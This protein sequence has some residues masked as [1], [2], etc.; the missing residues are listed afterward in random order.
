MAAQ[1]GTVHTVI[2]DASSI[3]RLDSSA[4]GALGEIARSLEASGVRFV[5]A[6][7]KGPVIDAL[8]RNGI[9][10][11]VAGEAP[12]L[13]VHDAVLGALKTPPPASD[14]DPREPLL[15]KAS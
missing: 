14:A 10:R 3:N 8:E 4:N 11:E 1:S 7:L 2:V 12:H 9:H 5:L 13:S 6:G 15:R